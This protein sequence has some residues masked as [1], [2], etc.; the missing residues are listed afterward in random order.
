MCL[1]HYSGQTLMIHQPEIRHWTAH[2]RPAG[3]H[4]P[5]SNEWAQGQEVSFH[6][7][8]STPSSTPSLA[9]ARHHSSGSHQGSKSSTDGAFCGILDMR[10]PTF[11]PRIVPLHSGHSVS[12]GSSSSFLDSF[13]FFGGAGSVSIKSS[14]RR[15][16]IIPPNHD[17]RVRSQ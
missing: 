4:Q 3:Q 13:S 1:P 12:S 8:I 5:L 16:G 17:S 9:L 15:I 7:V 11:P 10:M 14:C 2:G 6:Y